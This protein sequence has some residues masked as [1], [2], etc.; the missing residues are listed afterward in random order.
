M[1]KKLLKV[2][3]LSEEISQTGESS[4]YKD[5]NRKSKGAYVG[6]KEEKQ[7]H[8]HPV[9]GGVHKQADCSVARTEAE[10]KE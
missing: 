8:I 7:P 6:G 2:L 4:G 10:H 3:F 5:G 1:P 9:D